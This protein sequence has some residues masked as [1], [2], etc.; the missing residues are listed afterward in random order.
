MFDDMN[1]RLALLRAQ[2]LDPSRV[3]IIWQKRRELDPELYRNQGL[4]MKIMPAQMK[5]IEAAE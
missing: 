3:A 5:P 4:S 1:C 2:E